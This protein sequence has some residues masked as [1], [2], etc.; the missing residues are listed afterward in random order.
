[1]EMKIRRMRNLMVALVFFLVLIS[2]AGLG[3]MSIDEIKEN[4][5]SQRFGVTQDW[6]EKPS[7]KYDTIEYDWSD[8]EP[9]LKEL[10]LEPMEIE[11]IG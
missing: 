3:Q 5:T 11:R 8:E 10:F 6:Q 9:M 4:P 1:M 7:M 2:V